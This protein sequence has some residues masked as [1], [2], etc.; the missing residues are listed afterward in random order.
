[1][2]H[3]LHR[4]LEYTM[5]VKDSHLCNMYCIDHLNTLWELKTDIYVKCITQIT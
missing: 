5:G 4:S 1:M 3:I 2:E